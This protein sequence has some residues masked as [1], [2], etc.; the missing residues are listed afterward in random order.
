MKTLTV[1]EMTLLDLVER[2]VMCTQEK[3]FSDKS[4]TKAQSFMNE[5]GARLSITD[6]QALLL[7]VFL[8]NCEDDKQTKQD[9]ARFFK[10]PSIQLMKFS[11]DIETLV[12]KDLIRMAY[13]YDDDL[14]YF[15]P[16]Q[17]IEAFE[18]NCLPKPKE[19]ETMKPI[20]LVDQ[21]TDLLDDLEK[22][23]INMN[24][25][26]DETCKLFAANENLQ[27][28][29][30][31][32]EANFGYADM[33][34]F[35][36]MMTRYVQLNDNHVTASEFE[37]YFQGR[38]P[39]RYQIRDLENGSHNL[40]VKEWVTFG[41]EDG[42]VDSSSWM[43]T[44]KAKTRFLSELNLSR[45]RQTSAYTILADKI[46]AKPLYY[47]DAT[48]HQIAQL[49]HL[50]DNN[51]FHLIQQRLQD[52]GMRK[53]F[54]CI[55]YGVPGTGKTETVLQLAKRTGRNIMQVNIPALRSKWVGETEKNIKDI[56]D[57]YRSFC[58][59]E[60][61]EPILLFNEADA[62]LGKRQEG[63]TGGVEKM[64][65]A[66]QN[67]ILQ[68]M[69]NL[70]GI[71]MA[72]TNL[73]GNLDAA[74]ERRFLYKV[75]FTRPSAAE[76]RHIWQSMLACLTDEQAEALAYRFHFTGGQIENIAR[77]YTVET[78]LNGEPEEYMAL[79]HKLCTDEKSLQHNHHAI[80]F[81]A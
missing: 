54:A 40:I 50:L 38:H 64:E 3:N 39:F 25:F 63:A 32:R 37:D 70:E 33:V 56:F 5:L 19:Y 52:R 81:S 53:G 72:T 6:R 16:K 2:I 55:F 67:I 36:V 15:V 10:S 13:D 69:E 9:L 75:E 68:E 51:Q 73:S 45:K 46:V 11:K 76:S 44:E 42:Q 57:S 8:N 35:V 1:K 12:K 4:M 66:M 30:A 22:Q 18:N 20:E 29:K 14:F 71:M 28:V 79:I 7:S 49:E 78:I 27:I 23:L 41:Y 62:V 17:T 47:N 61:V 34:L 24:L 43:L 48:T 31:F 21:L 74:F 80:G 65:N 58:H 59:S 60:E 26:Y 77:K